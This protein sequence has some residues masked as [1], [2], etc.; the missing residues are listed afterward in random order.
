MRKLIVFNHVTLDGYFVDAGGGMT[1]AY[2]GNDDPE[3]QQ[4]VAENAQGGGELVFG[5]KTYDLMASYWPTPVA[6]QQNPEVARGMNAMRKYVAS[7][8]MKAA[9]WSNTILLQGELTAAVRALKMKDGPGLCLL[10]SGNVV[11]QLAAA[12][13]IDEYQFILDP[14]AL[15]SGRTM[16]ENVPAPVHLKLA[17]SR[18]FRN[19]KIYLAYEQA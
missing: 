16:F 5:R 11:A 3:F 2:A 9:A 18:V 8:T 13:L 12:G 4:F 10:G 19:G 6:E 7:R 1:W 15:G 17:R 14:L